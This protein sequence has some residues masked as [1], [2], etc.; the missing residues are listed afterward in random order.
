MPKRH[1]C[2]SLWVSLNQKDGLS[3]LDILRCA[4]Q[5]AEM[6]T[7]IIEVCWQLKSASKPN[8]WP[9]FMGFKVGFCG[10]YGFYANK[11]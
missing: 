2:Y 1:Y 3:A 6:L 8:F 10:F 7:T 5:H 4:C 11:L 9:N